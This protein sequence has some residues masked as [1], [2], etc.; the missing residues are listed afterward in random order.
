MS[1]II[2]IPEKEVIKITLQSKEVT[3]VL[4][5]KET[6]KIVESENAF[7]VDITDE[8]SNVCI[9]TNLVQGG[10]GSCSG[11]TCLIGTPTDGIW[12]DGAAP[13]VAEDTIADGV[14]KINEILSYLLPDPPLPLSDILINTVYHSGY[15]AVGLSN[16]GSRNYSTLYSDLI[17]TPNVTAT[18]LNT[19]RFSNADKGILSV[20]HNNEEIDSFN[21]E[22]A[23]NPLEKEGSQSYPP[24][25]GNANIITIN[26]VSWYN[27]FPAYQKGNASINLNGV[28]VE[29]E[30][31]LYL[32]HSTNNVTTP[33]HTFLYDNGNTPSIIAFESDIFSETTKYLSGIKYLTTGTVFNFS[34]SASNIFNKTYINS[35]VVINGNVIATT[36]INWNDSNSSGYSIPPNYLDSWTLSNK[37]INMYGNGSGDYL[38]FSTYA[39]DP[40]SISTSV[41]NTKI[42]HLYNTYSISSTDKHEYFRDEYYRLPASSYDTIPNT[43]TNQWDSSLALIDGEAQV[44]INRLVKPSI[45]FNSGVYTPIQDANRDYSIFTSSAFYYRAFRDSS[46][47]RNSGSLVVG[48]ITKADIDNSKVI[49]SLKLPTQ[50]GWLDLNKFFSVATFTGSDNDGCLTSYSYSGGA[51]TLNWTSGTFSTVNSGFMYILKIQITDNNIAINNL[52]DFGG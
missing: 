44:Y 46:S 21:L 3:S 18:T 31:T 13:I 2:N 45:N 4:S 49:L 50:T 20:F 36:N 40:F 35:P 48:N 26:S 47:P 9:N 7:T 30:N 6:L 32:K 37:H 43:I 33:I 29:G 15:I 34:V 23:F 16:I 22:T 17:N 14:D 52:Y 41:T 38:Q 27:N 12:S 8:C 24:A 11:D 10:S 1:C 28:V 42:N 25:S 5:T 39:K 51:L 19:N